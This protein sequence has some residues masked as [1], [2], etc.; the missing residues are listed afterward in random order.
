MGL[1][2]QFETKP[3]TVGRVGSKIHSKQWIKVH[4]TDIRHTGR[5]PMASITHRH[6]AD[7]FRLKK[8]DQ[9]KLATMLLHH[10][11]ATRTTRRDLGAKL[12]LRSITKEGEQDSPA[13][14]INNF[15]THLSC[16]DDDLEKL[17]NHIRTW[18]YVPNQRAYDAAPDHI[19]YTARK[20]FNFPPELVV[21]APV[22][23]DDELI[24]VITA[25]QDSDP[26]TIRHVSENYNGFWHM[27]RFSAHVEQDMRPKRTEQNEWDA[28][29]VRGAM[30]IIPHDPRAPQNRPHF[31]IH[32]RPRSETNSPDF[33]KVTGALLSLGRRAHLKFVGRE[34]RTNYPFEI[35]AS[36][37]VEKENT[38]SGLITRKHEQGQIFTARIALVR[39]K[40]GSLAELDTKIGVYCESQLKQDMREE[41]PHIDTILTTLRNLPPYDGK[42]G[43]LM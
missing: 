38:V 11:I 36:Q 7:G 32:Y 5:T 10:M 9:Q 27:L 33:K 14:S 1:R 25:I 28:Y 31:E 15:L 3:L 37:S 22:S 34:F 43:L 41:I 24:S 13:R 19:R 40:A 29:V 35:I 2:G 12:K 26:D 17:Y 16:S 21:P 8:E 18:L 30:Q 6:Q 23:L 20:L 42:S 4:E 39:A